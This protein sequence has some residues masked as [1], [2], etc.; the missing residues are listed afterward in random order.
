MVAPVCLQDLSPDLAEF[1][2]VHVVTPLKLLKVSLDG[3]PYLLS[4]ICS[5]QLAV[6]SRFPEDIF[7]L[8]M[9]LIKLFNST[10]PD[11]DP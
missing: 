9:L 1:N 10:D 6:I 7:S 4:V 2:E 11:T 8:T 5:T 3:I